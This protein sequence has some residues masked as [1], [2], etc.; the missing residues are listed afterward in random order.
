[1]TV[2][3]CVCEGE[4]ESLGTT[5]KSMNDHRTSRNL[6]ILRGIGKYGV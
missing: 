6:K 5:A 3:V 2:Y 1:M 4:K